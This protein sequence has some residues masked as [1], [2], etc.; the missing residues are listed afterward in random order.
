MDRSLPADT[1][2]AG[3]KEFF[4]VG[5]RGVLALV[6]SCALMTWAWLRLSDSLESNESFRLIRTGTAAQR[7]TAAGHLRSETGDQ[8]VQRAFAALI[9]ALGDDDAEVRGMAAQSLAVLVNQLQGRPAITPSETGLLKTRIDTAVR[10]LVKLLADP[11]V[12]VRV[13]ATQ[14]LG[15]M[16]RSGRSSPTAEQ[17]EAMTDESNAVRRAAALE[18][19][20]SRD[21]PLP[22][23]LAA[24]LADP[25]AAVR[26]AAARALARFPTALDETVPTLLLMIENDEPG[27]RRACVAAL[28]AAW[29]ASPLAPTLVAALGSRESEVRYLATMLLGRIGSEA[30]AARPALIALL[31]EP[32]PA[33]ATGRSDAPFPPRVL[34]AAAARAL[35]Q[36][37]PSQEVVAALVKM[38]SG[39]LDDRLFAAAGAIGALGPPAAAAVPALIDAYKRVLDSH[40]SVIGQIAL[41]AALGRVGPG[42][43][44]A[45]DAIA[46]LIRALDSSDPWIHPGAVRA[47]GQFVRAAA[48]AIPRLK[49]LRAA[50]DSRLRDDVEAALAAIEGRAQPSK[51]TTTIPSPSTGPRPASAAD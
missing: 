45:A 20:G 51:V 3:R 44:R 37:G 28:S 48:P 18:A 9:N 42:S 24:M 22:P 25:S 35:G 36:M 39:E 40:Q 30:R 6:A 43:A 2:V 15:S 32:L 14:G 27:V 1:K 31:K 47:L 49:A 4:Q 21:M 41:P 33:Q 8:E 10:G 38:L 5:L 50:P 17:L 26:T 13:A 19:W 7:R 46:I 29:P 34:A 16:V 11:D 12:A 23:E